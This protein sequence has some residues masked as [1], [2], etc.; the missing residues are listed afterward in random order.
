MNDDT[1]GQ[2]AGSESPGPGDQVE[3]GGILAPRLGPIHFPTLEMGGYALALVLTLLA[4]GLTAYHWLT[5]GVL[6][7]VILALAFLQGAV[8]LG[9]FMHLREGRGTLWHLPVL[10][11]A[12][13]VALGIV[14][15]SLWI[16][17]FKSGVS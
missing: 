12:L 5:P 11:L 15:F 6:I 10:G 3:I 1:H 8:Q 13:F 14:G 17:M 16:M 9:V 4:F 2:T 7:P